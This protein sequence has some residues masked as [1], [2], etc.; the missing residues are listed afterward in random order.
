MPKVIRASPLN[1]DVTVRSGQHLEI[2]FRYLL[3]SLR[4]L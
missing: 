3:A 2:C 4:D 1:R